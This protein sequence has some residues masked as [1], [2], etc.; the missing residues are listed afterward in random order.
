MSVVV[1][2]PVPVPENIATPRAFVV[3]VALAVPVARI[4][5]VALAVRVALTVAM[6]FAVALMDTVRRTSL[7]AHRTPLL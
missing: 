3:S 2:M 6:N 7:G 1:M 5:F 4:L